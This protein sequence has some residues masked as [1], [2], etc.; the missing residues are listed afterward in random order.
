MSSLPTAFFSALVQ[1]WQIHPT[2]LRVLHGLYTTLS[3]QGPLRPWLA[4]GILLATL[5]LV[6]ARPRGLDVAWAAGMGALATLAL[7]LIGLRS[8]TT[9][10]GDVWDAAATLIALFM[11]SEALASNGFFI[12]AA[13]W[14]ARLAHGSGWRL[15]GLTLLLTTGVAALL[16]NDGAILMLT[17]I[18]VKLL[19]QIYPDARNRLPYLF[20]LGFFADAMSG[21]FIPS[22]LTNIII[23]D[24]S[25]LTVTRALLWTLLP[26]LAVFLVAGGAFALRFHIRLGMRYDASVVEAPVEAIRDQLL[27]W[28]GWAALAVLVSGYALVSVLRLPVS[29]VSVSVALALLTLTGLRF[30]GAVRQAV[31]D[32]PWG[33]LVYALGMFVVMTAA[34]NAGVLA[35]VTRPLATSVQVASGALG[36]LAAGMLVALLA[37]AVNNLPAALIGVLSLRA[38]GMASVSQ[39]AVYAILLGVDIGPKLTPF[40]SLATLLWFGILARNETPISWGHY[41][42]ENWWVTVLALA[43]A[44]LA[45]LIPAALLG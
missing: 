24:A 31:F 12:W 37:A 6:I 13:R 10:F 1:I 17:P 5:A 34:Y 21:L 38:V 29:L 7:G 28:L 41:L 11:L 4:G 42:R 36:G 16:A 27:F 39:I 3:G 30:R 15:Y 26:T 8:L 40:G 35:I 33:I 25:G 20:A 43:A 44:L 9:I 2:I 45:L 22:N 19:T 18:Y 23:A 32:A 14:L